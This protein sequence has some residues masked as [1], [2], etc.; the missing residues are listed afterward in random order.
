M[1]VILSVD[2]LARPMAGIGRYTYELAQGLQRRNEIDQLRFQFRL[3]WSQDPSTL[4]GSTRS[5]FSG[6]WYDLARNGYRKVAPALKGFQLRNYR[7][8]L[9]HSTNYELPWF[10]GKTVTTVHDMS[11]FRHPEFHPRERV[12]NMHRIF[13][14]ILKSA[15][16][17]ITVSD[18]SKF[19]LAEMC[20]VNPE[21]I[22]TT[23]LGCD[24]K[25]QPRSYEQCVDVLTS[26]GLNY[27]G[28]ALTVGTIEP[29]KN[30]E[31][32]IDAYSRLPHELKMTYPLVVVGGYGWKSESV[33]LKINAYSQEGWL[34][35][36]SYVPDDVLPI[37]YSGARVISYI[38][39]YEGFGLP[40]LEAMASGVPVITSKVASIPEVG[41]SAVCYVSTTDIEE[42]QHALQ[43]LLTD[44]FYRMELA[45]SGLKQ[46]GKFSWD[47]TVAQTLAAYRQIA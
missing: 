2:P 26:L 1:K 36:L 46:A 32:L 45:E 18:F 41:G 44:D 43:R 7:D 31:A 15:D 34:K 13:P 42:I 9:F 28:Y 5:E 6:F 33:H 8:Y 21:K 10:S 30:I 40:V 38:S 11:C 14:R 12:D 16:L 23:H 20:R 39:L 4:L 17:F 47:K 27:Q 25:F 3:G 35:Y 29:R 22:V 24:A 37:L 19:E